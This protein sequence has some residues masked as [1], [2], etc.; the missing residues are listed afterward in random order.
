MVGMRPP[1][2]LDSCALV[3][4]VP[5]SLSANRVTQPQAKTVRQAIGC[6]S[7]FM[8]IHPD[9]GST[10][11]EC[12]GYRRARVRAAFGTSVL[13]ARSFGLLSRQ[14]APE[15]NS[16]GRIAGDYCLLSERSGSPKTLSDQ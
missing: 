4:D 16:P 14:G 5:I 15:E 6:L 3:R 2:V 7:N 9:E 8:F 10:P 12:T 13:V 11:C 1:A